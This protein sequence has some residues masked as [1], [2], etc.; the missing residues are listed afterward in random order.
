MR[1][2]APT[3]VTIGI[4]GSGRTIADNAAASYVRGEGRE[5]H[6]I[7]NTWSDV[8]CGRETTNIRFDGGCR[9]GC[10]AQADEHS[11]G[12][13]WEVNV[14]VV[15][16]DEQLHHR[17]VIELHRHCKYKQTILRLA[18]RYSSS[19]RRCRRYYDSAAAIA[20]DMT[21]LWATKNGLPGSGTTY[22]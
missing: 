7:H 11:E 9:G 16:S 21:I 1:T 12:G 4:A 22:I 20:T 13:E 3:N 8:A 6:W 2:V 15:L 5:G 18:L 19:S 14:G 10:G 17:M